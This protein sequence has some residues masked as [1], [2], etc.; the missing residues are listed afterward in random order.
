[1]KE[2]HPEQTVTADIFCCSQKV[3]LGR[4]ELSSS[5]GEWSVVAMVLPMFGVPQQD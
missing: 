3:G 5:P 2:N 1:M 4:V